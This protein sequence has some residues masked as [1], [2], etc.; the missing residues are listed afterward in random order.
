M[1]LDRKNN[2]ALSL[3]RTFVTGGQPFEYQSCSINANG[4]GSMDG[5]FT[6]VIVDGDQTGYKFDALVGIHPPSVIAILD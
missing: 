4:N 6:F 1:I 5:Y 2:W 3:L